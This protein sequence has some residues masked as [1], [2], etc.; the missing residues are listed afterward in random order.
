MRSTAALAI[1]FAPLAV[2]VLLSVPARPCS[3][4]DSVL[5]VG[6][7][8]GSPFKGSAYVSYLHG[9]WARSSQW[10]DKIV[11]AVIEFDAGLGGGRISLGRGADVELGAGTIKLSALRTWGWPW[12]TEPNLTYV[13]PEVDFAVFFVRADLGV[14]FKVQGDGGKDTLV[15]F[16]LGLRIPKHI[17]G[18][19]RRR[20][21]PE[22]R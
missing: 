12:L 11:G 3:G 1:R 16:G 2:V 5:A 9:G 15:T 19:R 17:H 20:R 14:L 7:V 21:P 6:V 18:E 22:G 4:G 13:G 8:G 10:G